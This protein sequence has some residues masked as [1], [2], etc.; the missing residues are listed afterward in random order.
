MKCK[1]EFVRHGF[2]KIIAFPPE[3]RENQVWIIPLNKKTFLVERSTVIAGIGN[4]IKNDVKAQILDTLSGGV[5][6]MISAFGDP[7]NA[8][9]AHCDEVAEKVKALIC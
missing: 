1:L 8:C 6:G 5:T 9:M 3:D 2:N 7:K 4:M